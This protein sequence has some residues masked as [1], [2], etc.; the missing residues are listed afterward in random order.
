MHAAGGVVVDNEHQGQVYQVCASSRTD[1][2]TLAPQSRSV[3]C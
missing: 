2:V 3:G 1:Q